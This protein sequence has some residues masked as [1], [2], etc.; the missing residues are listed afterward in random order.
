M[1][2]EA[3]LRAA[4]P[5][6]GGG[7]LRVADMF[8]GA[9]G[10]SSGFRQAGWN[11]VLGVDT[12]A[13]SMATYSKNFPT[14]QTFL[15]SIDDP[16]VEKL[17]RHA[18]VDVICGGPPC[19]GFS[20]NDPHNFR[21]GSSKTTLNHLPVS[22]AKLCVRLQ[23]RVVVMEEVQAFK[24]DKFAPIRNNVLRILKMAGYNI[25]EGIMRAE[26]YAVPQCRRRY[27]LVGRLDGPAPTMPPPPTVASPVTVG[28]ALLSKDRQRVPVA[29]SIREKVLARS[30]GKLDKY[31]A[32]TYRIIDRDRPSHTITGNF[33][34]PSSGR[35]TLQHNGELWR[36]C[37][38]DGADLQ[39][40]PESHTFVGVP[41]SV[42]RQIG[43]AVPPLMARALA[44]HI[45]R[46][47]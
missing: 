39:S 3:Q 20:T 25:T 29:G 27:V 9:G 10:F 43:N 36:L 16:K 46:T 13:D 42:C 35:Y 23:P 32:N 45:G 11:P 47:I 38:R 18:K 34:H 26:E 31:F 2:G 15:G 41:N 30:A 17:L 4:K 19:Q 40:F 1:L 44:K 37:E 7:G 8:C 22:F 24:N 21:P 6:T 33:A 5:L 14:A 12:D 28:Q